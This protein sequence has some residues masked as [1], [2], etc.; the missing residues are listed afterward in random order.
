[1]NTATDL[2]DWAESIICN[3]LPMD[4]CTQEEWD[5]MVRDW[6]DAKNNQPTTQPANP[7]PPNAMPTDQT[8]KTLPDEQNIGH[9]PADKTQR[10][11]DTIE[12]RSPHPGHKDEAIIRA[13]YTLCDKVREQAAEIKRLSRALGNA[14]GAIECA[15]GFDEVRLHPLGQKI[16][17]TLRAARTAIA[18]AK[19]Q[20]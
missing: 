1:M 14:A 15:L 5:K 17:V 19:G 9:T 8:S 20:P 11:I 18:K 6:R 13:A 12:L 3:G 7:Q 2:L 10:A 4:H 16:E